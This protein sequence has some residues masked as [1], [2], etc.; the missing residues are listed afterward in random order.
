MNINFLNT[1]MKE[2]FEWGPEVGALEEVVGR[3][4]LGQTYITICLKGFLMIA[5]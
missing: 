4:V 3:V 5:I 1:W 2:L